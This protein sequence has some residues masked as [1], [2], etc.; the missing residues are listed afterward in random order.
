MY[1][2]GRKHMKIA[3]NN[4]QRNRKLYESLV[5]VIILFLVNRLFES[6]D[7]IKQDFAHYLVWSKKKNFVDLQAWIES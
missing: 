4:K 7:K 1:Q 6:E 3:I 5:R 2:I